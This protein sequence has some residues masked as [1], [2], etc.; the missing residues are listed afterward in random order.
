MHG[1]AERHYNLDAGQEDTSEEKANRQ[2]VHAWRARLASR[3]SGPPDDMKSGMDHW[4]DEGEQRGDNSAVEQG[5]ALEK[6]RQNA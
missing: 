2:L 5:E 1:S 3:P 6:K 4:R